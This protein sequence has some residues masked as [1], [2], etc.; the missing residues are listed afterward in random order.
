MN[1]GERLDLIKSVM[2]VLS[3]M[4]TPDAYLHVSEFASHFVGTW[5][6]WLE[7]N[8]T[9]DLDSWIVWSLRQLTDGEL[10]GLY[11]Y[12]VAEVARVDESDLPWRDGE[13]KLFLSHI[14]KEKHFL[15]LLASSLGH[16]GVHGFVAHEHI[17]PGKA[18][19]EVIRSCL[20]TCDALVA[21]LHDGFHES[22]WTDQEVGF[23]MGQHKFA[24]AVRAGIDPY[25]FIGAIQ[26][27]PAPPRMFP[28]SEDP[29]G[30]ARVLARDIVQVLAAERRTR[31][32]LRDALVNRLCSSRSWNM[33]NEIVDLL[34][35]TPKLTRDQ[36]SK[37][38][39]AAQS[40]VE[41]GDAFSVGP[42]LH[43]LSAEYDQ[44][45]TRDPFVDDVPF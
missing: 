16:Y 40:N 2:P 36:Y 24:V 32:G 21:V 23:V 30:A 4:S 39:E 45:P 28:P 5:E 43:E 1:P 11:E 34:R 18:W 33:S 9:N 8:N 14:A 15:S 12:L 17:D 27:I 29:D 31:H 13:F 44:Q 19:A 38:M 6:W 35:Q 25:G 20:F 41:V 7:E 10:R 22:S 26:G 42:F 3:N 37:L